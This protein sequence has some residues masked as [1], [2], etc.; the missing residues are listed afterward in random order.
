MVFNVG[1][2]ASMPDPD[3]RAPRGAGSGASGAQRAGNRR[4]EQRQRRRAARI[5]TE[6]VSLV[7]ELTRA[8]RARDR[9]RLALYVRMLAAA[10]VQVI[11][12]A[13]VVIGSSDDALAR[14]ARYEA[15]VLE[16]AV[17]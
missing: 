7:E 15:A 9:D 10:H 16:Y 8:Q 4:K 6:G 11:C 5:P 1:M 12:D 2:N 14:H 13:G 3:P 17:G